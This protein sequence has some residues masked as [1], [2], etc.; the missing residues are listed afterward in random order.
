MSFGKVY[1]D[2]TFVFGPALIEA[3]SIQKDGRG[4]GL[5]CVSVSTEVA[6][7]CS[8]LARSF[9]AQPG[10]SPFASELVVDDET[11][12]VFVDHLGI[13]LDEE[14]DIR[15]PE[16][17]LPRYKKT[18]RNQLREL[19]LGRA[20]DKWRWLADYHDWALRSRGWN[21]RSYVTG[22]RAEHSFTSFGDVIRAAAQ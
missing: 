16:Y 18:I 4:P 6:Q 10:N 3:N 17:L 13:W 12:T 22:L 15:V 1:M 8:T 11:L 5:P 19:P 21:R 14:D 20:R 2:P 7:Y 9:Y